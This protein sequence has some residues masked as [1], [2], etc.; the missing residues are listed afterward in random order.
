M[1]KNRKNMG[2]SKESVAGRLR[3][4]TPG[5]RLEVSLRRVKYM[6]VAGALYRLRLE[7]MEY[8][9]MISPDR[10]HVTVERIS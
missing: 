9:S 1:S 6:S 8:T 10:K 3:R 7:G 4:M 2:K 5:E